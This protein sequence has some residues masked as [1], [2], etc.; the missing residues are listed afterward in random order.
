MVT[1]SEGHRNRCKRPPGVELVGS[2]YT[3]QMTLGRWPTVD[4]RHHVTCI[5][6][7]L[8]DDREIGEGVCRCG[9]LLEATEIELL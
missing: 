9:K 6:D 8:S 7:M 2:S 4:V 5:L 1:L 3:A